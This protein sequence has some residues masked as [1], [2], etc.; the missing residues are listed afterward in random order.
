MTARHRRCCSSTIWSG[1]DYPQARE[2]IAGTHDWR[3]VSV[4]QSTGYVKSLTTVA[5]EIYVEMRKMAKHLEQEDV[6]LRVHPMWP[7]S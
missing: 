7:K 3:A 5:N 1:R 6:I 4:C 2:A